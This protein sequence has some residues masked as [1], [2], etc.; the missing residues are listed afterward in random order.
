[1]RRL[2]GL[3]RGTSVLEYGLLVAVIAGLVV[4]VLVAIGGFLRAAH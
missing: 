3:D 4:V 2:D 1:M